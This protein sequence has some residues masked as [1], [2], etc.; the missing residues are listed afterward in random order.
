[1]SGK[2]TRSLLLSDTMLPKFTSACRDPL[3]EIPGSFLS[4]LGLLA[5]LPTS[6]GLP[7][8]AGCAV[9]G[10]VLSLKESTNLFFVS[11]FSLTSIKVFT[12]R[13]ETVALDTGGNLLFR[14]NP[15]FWLFGLDL[16]LSR[17]PVF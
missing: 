5:Y 2:S 8:R 16:S 13:F 17:F 12:E 6:S 1:M 7:L 10:S 15:L 4:S 14:G 11:L 3:D 9:K